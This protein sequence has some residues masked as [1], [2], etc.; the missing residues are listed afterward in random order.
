MELSEDYYEALL[1]GKG[2]QFAKNAFGNGSFAA[3]EASTLSNDGKDRRT[4]SYGG[5]EILMEKHLKHGV[6]DSLADTLR[7]HFEWIPGK[8]LLVIGHC[9]KHLSL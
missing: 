1:E 4:F 3:K 2:D 9:G 6:K 8:K 7:I 5:S